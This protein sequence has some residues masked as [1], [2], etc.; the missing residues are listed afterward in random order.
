MNATLKLSQKIEFRFVVAGLLA[1]ATASLVLTFIVVLKYRVI[2]GLP[3]QNIFRDEIDYHLYKQI[4]RN[5]FFK[6]FPCIAL[7]NI[8]AAWKILKYGKQIQRVADPEA[9]LPGPS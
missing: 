8:W 3:W 7:V 2:F 9:T 6:V 1:V 5:V 4:F